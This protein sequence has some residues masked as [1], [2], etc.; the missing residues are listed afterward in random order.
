MKKGLILG[1]IIAI[2][3]LAIAGYFFMKVP[4]QPS[5]IPSIDT[6]PTSPVTSP[7]QLTPPSQTPPTSTP[8]TYNIEIKSFAFNNDTLNIKVGDS[9]IW[10][11]KDSASHSIISDSGTE[12]SSPV[13]STGQTY[14]H[15]FATAGTYEY[16]C[17]IHTS[18]KGKVIVS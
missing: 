11:N 6:R 12:I 8:S 17:G 1:I 13:I 7:D 14:S 3:I 2:V 4:T 5:T 15:T 10:T 18:M 16:H 9:I